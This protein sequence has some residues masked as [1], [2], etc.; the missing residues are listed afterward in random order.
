MRIA[1]IVALAASLTSAGSAQ[2]KQPLTHELLWSFQRVG[3][4]VPSP[5]GKWVVFSV[6]EP[7]YDP[8]KEITD[9]WIVP[10][11]GS[12]APRRLTSTRA[13]EGGPAWSSD[14]GRLA[15]SARRDDDEVS[16]IYVLDVDR[17]GEAQRVTNAPTAASAPAWS[18][19][20]KRI[21]FQAVLW[22][23]ASD[24]ES[25]RKA[26]QEKKN[27]KSKA[28]IYDAFPVRNWDQWIEESKPHLWVVDVAGDRKARSLFGGS[29]LA[30]AT[31]FSSDALGAVWSPDGSS[32]IFAATER[33]DTA[34][35]A[36][37]PSH[38][39]QV[40][41]SG[42]EPR[43]LSPDGLDSS[44][45]RF[46]PDGGA[47]CFLVGD[48]KPA[49]YQ[50]TRI[51]CAP[52]PMTTTASSSNVRV[53]TRAFDRAVGSWAFTPDSKNILFTAEDAGHER[54]YQ[55]PV[56]GGET[57]VA[58]DAP[59]GVY[60]GLQIP[61]AAASTILFA[62]WESAISPAEVV[63][64]NAANGERKAL[65]S[66]NTE[67]A[68]SIDW[69]PLREFSFT[70][71]NGRRIHSLVALPP[72]F[73]E[74]KRYPLFVLIHGGH[75]SMWRDAITYRWNYHLL[76]QPG[77]VVLMT[78]YRGSTGYGEKFTLDILGDPLAGPADDIN[79]AADEAI[80]R[81][82][83]IDGS[84][85]AAGGASYGGHLTNWLAGTT[86]RY[87]ALI[88]HA[89][90]ATLDMQ[91]GTSDSIYHREVMMGGPYWQNPQKWIEQSPLA[92]AG[93]F[94]TPM[95]VS[96]GENDFRVPEGNSLAIFAALQRMNVPSRLVV[97]PDE[98]H[99]ILKGENSRVF[100]R[101]VRQWLEKYLTGS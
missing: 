68:R 69:L 73:D 4:P 18:P 70:G 5:D 61:R 82:P 67:K 28:R 25:N 86:T 26:A 3:P 97:W 89:G 32:V 57:K 77:F 27:A 98:N 22:P 74:S 49:I 10:G 21:V 29:A 7:S 92:K 96:I 50:L 38:L 34:A 19:D 20:G 85:Q 91:W 71:R 59:Q 13:G 30:R 48:A 55:V 101:E 54:I 95:L 42:G 84:R 46:R 56:E 65:T 90:L 53:I 40:Q 81:F 75:A 87:K 12:A 1:L 64:V 41:A 9:L 58:V 78:D 2:S 88:S 47:L 36:N 51:G 37:P 15:F 14:G 80:K 23:G 63:R 60:T 44:G 39:W 6:N 83:F 17:G 8:Q 99:W 11:D 33:G 16:Q 52:W 43:R 79:D 45:P 100:Y 31:G 24:E 94:K 62:N 93:N 76:S 72:N 66:F 35:R